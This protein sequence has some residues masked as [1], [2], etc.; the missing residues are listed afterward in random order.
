MSPPVSAS[1][2]VSC[3]RFADVSAAWNTFSLQRIEAPRHLET[4]FADH[5]VTLHISGT[6]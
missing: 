3:C 6:A 1:Q 2:F 4:T 5:V